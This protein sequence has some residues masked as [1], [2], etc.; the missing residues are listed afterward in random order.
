MTSAGTYR[1]NADIAITSMY[2]DPAGIFWLGGSHGLFRFDPSNGAST[3][4]PQR[5]PNGLA[6]D[7][8]GIA[9]DGAGKL[10]L[11][12][13][14]DAEN[15]FDP[16]TGTYARRWPAPK[17]QAVRGSTSI[18]AGPDGVLWRG[19]PKGLELFD[20]STGAF[21]VLGHDA[22]DRHSLSGNEIL[23]L[24]TDRDGSL[25]VGTKEGG[26][27]RFSPASLRFGAWR[28]N[29]ADS[30]SLSDENVRAIYADR[31]GV[32]WLG[33]YNGGLNRY[34]AASGTFTHF[35]HDAR[36]PASL[37]DDRVYSIYEDRAGYL[38]VG[39]GLG[40]NRL[41]RKTGA[42]THFERG[43]TDKKGSPIP[44]YWFLE[45]RRQVFWFGAGTLK[46]SSRPADR[47]SYVELLSP[48]CP[49]SRTTMATCGSARRV[50]WRGRI[51]AATFEYFRGRSRRA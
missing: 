18:F 45:D 7:I 22:A 29:P 38:W 51:M 31:A 11:A 49:C 9:R 3:H 26:V 34:D 35:R 5:R 14:E 15:V 46:A 44:T 21:A 25:W 24:A 6:T 13:T 20:P 19:T 48:A 16:N 40:I 50:A 47:R 32:L 23:S 33:T 41:D 17:T 12:T 1:P 2:R 43:E 36:N 39:T 4:Y 37:D 30:R 8:R 27:N 28:R 10:W 42:F